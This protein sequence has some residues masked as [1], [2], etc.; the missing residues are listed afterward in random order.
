MCLTYFIINIS[1]V[2]FATY[3]LSNIVLYLKIRTRSPTWN[4]ALARDRGSADTGTGSTINS[5]VL[6]F[7]GDVL[8]LEGILLLYFEIIACN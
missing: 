8:I 5:P 4:F 6:A 1:V 3:P 2:H 7:K